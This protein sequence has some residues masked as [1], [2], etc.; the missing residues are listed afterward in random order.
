ME[1]LI[2]QKNVYMISMKDLRGSC[3]NI[4]V[5]G[6]EQISTEIEGINLDD[7]LKSFKNKKATG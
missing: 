4:E 1:F 6:I 2:K 7:S 3:V 5:L